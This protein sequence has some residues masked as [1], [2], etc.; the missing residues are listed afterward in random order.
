MKEIIQNSVQS[1]SLRWQRS[2]AEVQC[3]VD[4]MVMVDVRRKWGC[5]VEK[6]EPHVCRQ[7]LQDITLIYDRFAPYN[8][9]YP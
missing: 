3:S 8:A 6:N 4:M 7:S 2:E 1:R 5:F 9:S